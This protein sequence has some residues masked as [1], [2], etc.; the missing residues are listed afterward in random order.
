MLDVET[1][2][3]TVVVIDGLARSIYLEED[4]AVERYTVAFAELCTV[5]LS[6]RDSRAKIEQCLH[7]LEPVP[8]ARTG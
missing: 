5:A 7:K 6:A 2:N 3:F 1:G 4:A 8:E